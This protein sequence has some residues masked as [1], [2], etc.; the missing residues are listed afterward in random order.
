[1]KPADSGM[2]GERRTEMKFP[3][4][5]R[6]EIRLFDKLIAKMKQGSEQG[7][8]R[9]QVEPVFRLEVERHY[10]RDINAREAEAVGDLAAT[11]VIFDR[12]RREGRDSVWTYVA[13]P[14]TPPALSLGSA[15]HT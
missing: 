15:G 12:L 9:A 1:M 8:T 10:K 2:V 7:Q 6:K 5:L 13:Q 3:G 4:I 11:Y 14:L